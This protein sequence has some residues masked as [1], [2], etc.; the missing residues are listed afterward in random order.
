M[1]SVWPASNL[2]RFVL[3]GQD[4]FVRAMPFTRN[5]VFSFFQ[6]QIRHHEE[7]ERRGDLVPVRKILLRQGCNLFQS[8]TNF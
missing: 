7:R 1:M 4:C 2:N 5:D 6:Q 8:M 3:C